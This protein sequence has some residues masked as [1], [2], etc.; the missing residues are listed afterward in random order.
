MGKFSGLEAPYLGLENG[1]TFR[2]PKREIVAIFSTRVGPVSHPSPSSSPRR[3]EIFRFRKVKTKTKSA[4]LFND[5]N[6]AYINISQ[7][8]IFSAMEEIFGQVRNNPNLRN[9]INKNKSSVCA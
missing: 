9:Q 4:K 2:H 7:I 8:P 1:R 3:Q 6:N 5:E